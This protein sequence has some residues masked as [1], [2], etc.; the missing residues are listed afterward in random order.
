MIKREVFVFSFRNTDNYSS[1]RGLGLDSLD[2]IKIVI[3][4]VISS[5]IGTL[6]HIISLFIGERTIT[7]IIGNKSAL[8]SD[9]VKDLDFSKTD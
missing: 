6:Y 9:T 5:A 4:R 3:K 7:R 1:K 8:K 2:I